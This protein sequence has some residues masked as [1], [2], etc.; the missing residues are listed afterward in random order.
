M[1]GRKSNSFTFSFLFY[2][3][4]FIY[5]LQECITSV[6]EKLSRTKGKRKV[7]NNEDL[8]MQYKYSIL[9]IIPFANEENITS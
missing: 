7:N 1:R 2:T 9:K 6:T 8:K 4:V 3:C 5:L